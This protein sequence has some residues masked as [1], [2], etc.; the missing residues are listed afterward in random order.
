MKRRQRFFARIVTLILLAG[1]LATAGGWWFVRR[2]WPQTQGT[3]TVAG[4]H[5]PVEINRDQYGVPNIYSQNEHDLFFAQGYVHA[6][7][8]LWQMDL[9]RRAGLGRLSELLGTATL[10]TDRLLRTIGT[11]RSAQQDLN[12]LKPETR[13]ILQAYADGVN[14]Y[15]TSH[16]SRLPLE[17]RI[18][19]VEAELWEP[20]HTVAWAKMMQFTNNDS[21]RRDISRA[22]AMQT[23]GTQAADAYTSYPEDGP[24]TLST[25]L[26]PSAAEG[27]QV[28]AQ[29]QLLPGTEIGSVDLEPVEQALAVAQI[30]VGGS[31]IGL[32]SNSWVISPKHSVTGR[33]LLAS[34]P[35]LEL[36]VPSV[37][38]QI[39]LHAPGFDVVGASLPGTIGVIIGH[40]NHIAWGLTNLEAD[41][42]DVYIER[43]DPSNA[44]A[45]EVDGRFVPFETVEEVI[46]VKGQAE[47]VT[48]QVQISRHGP[49]LNQVVKDLQQPIAL[50]WLAAAS[51]STL[52][53]AIIPI[54]RAASWEQFQEALR[55]WDAPMQNFMYAD[56][57]GNIGYYAAGAV[58]ARTKPSGLT[59]LPGWNSEHEWPSPIPFEQLPHIFNPE[60]GIIVS[61]NNKPVPHDYP[62]Y[63][64]SSWAA[65]WRAQRILAQLNAKERLTLDDMAAAQ[66]DNISIFGQTLTPYL[67]AA[68][69]EDVNVQQAQAKLA[70]WDYR[71]AADSVAAGI[72]EVAVWHLARAVVEDEVQQAGLP[73]RFLGLGANREFLER[74]LKNP[75]NVWWDD[76]RT[77]ARETRDLIIEQ[78]LTQSVEWWRANAGNDINSWSWGAIHSTTFRHAVFG[79]IPLIQHIFNVT[80]GPTDGDLDTPQ[81][82]NF[83]FDHPFS[84]RHGPGYRQVIDVGNWEESRAAVSVGQ[85]GHA[86]H[87]HYAD[88][89]PLWRSV[90]H[91]PM[92]W[93]QESI[94]SSK[95][96]HRLVLQP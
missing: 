72:Y 82:N 67:L 27:R 95:H 75:E 43:L 25:A 57:S 88:L 10:E 58:P 30:P 56:S 96:N 37:W 77:P 93:N 78:V 38:Y 61:A 12:G 65:P 14:A 7:D 17:Y 62:F 89:V 74:L 80:A 6:Q 28:L 79:D 44:H 87:P 69:T 63:L 81:A 85:S 60:S 33:P 19:R 18:L 4:L 11:N 5:A 55:L 42:Q 32:G 53:D 16:R 8:R 73:D 91:H 59:P 54:N 46:R 92:L 51:P 1:I 70:A 68:K 2:S 24:T 83:S 48:L 52:V 21:W 22:R 9:Q 15:I 71:L 40:N 31:S 13:S 41:V 64:G 36:G 50:K 35:H 45:Y 76:L 20:L 90:Q 29:E 23:I 86:F 39:G 34:D 47:P 26:A 3:L 66:A 84:V 49:L 94:R